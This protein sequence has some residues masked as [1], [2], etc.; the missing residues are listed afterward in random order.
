LPVAAS[1]QQ[2]A[3]ESVELLAL[4]PPPRRT[5]EKSGSPQKQS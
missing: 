1:E 4:Q 3:L 2:S 5:A